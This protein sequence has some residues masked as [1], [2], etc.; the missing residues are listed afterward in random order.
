MIDW[1][2]SSIAIQLGP[3]PIYWY[4][5]AYA[6]G[7]AVAYAVMVG[8]ARRLHLNADLIG[9]GLIIIAVAALIGGRLYHV[10]DQFN[11]CPP[12]FPDGPCYRD[13]LLKIVLPPYS[14]LGVYGGIVTGSI[15]FILYC[16]YQG[17]S[18]WAYADVVA[19]G[20][21]AMQ[22]IGRWGNFFNQELYGPPTNLPWG[23]A[24]DCAH[25]VAP[26]TCDAYPL[27]TT[28]FQPLF[29]Y[30]SISGLVGMTVLIWIARR[31]PKWYLA[32]DLLAIF[33]VWYSIVRY[34]LENL[35]TN[36]WKLEG[37][38]TAQI[39]SIIFATVG[40]VLILYRHSRRTDDDEAEDAEEPGDP[41]VSDPSEPGHRPE[42][43][44]R[45]TA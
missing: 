2:P 10:I 32:G 29:L 8:Q 5:I 3:I 26:W 22:A 37:V 13:N 23:I 9:N 16:R 42:R 7:L 17:I 27:T 25:R 44:N 30:E 33:F 20:L 11:A 1:T 28:H 6:V 31:R 35:R 34:V 12:T 41:D 43:S 38:P 21:F 14:G 19:P 18:A 45:S 40:I 39:F 36:N 15:A 24:I 4:G